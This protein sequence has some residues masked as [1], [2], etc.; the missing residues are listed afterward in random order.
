[1][2]PKIMLNLIPGYC[3]MRYYITDPGRITECNSAV[4]FKQF[5]IEPFSHRI[6]SSLNY[7]AH[8]LKRAMHHMKEAD[9][10]VKTFCIYAPMEAFS[11][12][13]YKVPYA[14]KATMNKK[15]SNIIYHNNL[16]ME[17]RSCQVSKTYVG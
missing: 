8:N 7:I 9:I 15:E 3:S 17:A 5:S 1:M 4:Y 6:F 13:C 12:L 11:Y 14:I 16:Q 10:A 2:K